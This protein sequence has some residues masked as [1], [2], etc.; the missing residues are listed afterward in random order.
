MSAVSK[1][2]GRLQAG[3]GI[4][5]VAIIALLA[6][7]SLVW[8]PH[9]GVAG[10]ATPLAEPDN[11][12]WLGTDQTGRDVVSALMSGTLMSLLLAWFAT[13]VSLVIGVPLGALLATR[14]GA[15]SQRQLVLVGILPAALCLGAVLGGLRVQSTL[16]VFLAIGLPGAVAAAIAARAILAPVLAADY[17]AAARLAGLDWL[18][19]GQRHVVPMVMPQ[20]VALGMELLAAAMLVEVTLSFAGLGV[21]GTGLSLGTMLRDGQQLAQVRPMLVIAPGAVALVTA[22]A[23]LISAGGLR[24]GGLR[25]ARRGAA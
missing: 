4:A 14:F 6:L 12:H 13:L 11:V 20:L 2:R 25:E 15:G 22:L 19:A 23:L 8:T 16:S 9:G 17:V 1:P 10:S 18:E 7:I 5:L 21:D 24:A 3:A